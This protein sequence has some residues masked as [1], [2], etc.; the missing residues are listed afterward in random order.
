MACTTLT[1]IEKEVASVSITE[2]GFAEVEY[3]NSMF[4]EP[5]E[6][7]NIIGSREA[8]GVRFVLSGAPLL[9]ASFR[10][11]ASYLRPGDTVKTV[12]YSDFK[13]MNGT[14]LRYMYEGNYEYK[15][16]KYSDLTVTVEM[17]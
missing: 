9:G 3:L 10:L 4:S 1:V 6:E 13:M 5:C 12:W 17:A 14:Y 16:G 8:V 15:A 11:T 2:V 7:D